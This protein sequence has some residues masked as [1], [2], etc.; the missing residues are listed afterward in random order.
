[1][2]VKQA[3]GAMHS[4][5]IVA[6]IGK[7]GIQLGRVIL[8]LDDSFPQFSESWAKIRKIECIRNTSVYEIRYNPVYQMIEII[9]RVLSGKG[10][11]KELD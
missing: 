10:G 1:M 6:E 11:E 5:F 3:I 2:T 7:D 9:F 4:D 8:R